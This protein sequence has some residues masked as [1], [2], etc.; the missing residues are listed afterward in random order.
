M[1]RHVIAPRIALARICTVR[2]G[3][4]TETPT[5]RLLLGALAEGHE[6]LFMADLDSSSQ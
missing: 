6:G 1:S 4:P 3:P 5:Q 2:A